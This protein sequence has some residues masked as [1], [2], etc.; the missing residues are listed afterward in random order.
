MP[1]MNSRRLPKSPLTSDVLQWIPDS[2][3]R[4]AAS[5]TVSGTSTLEGATSG[6]DTSVPAMPGKDADQ[7]ASSQGGDNRDDGTVENSSRSSW[8]EL[9]RFVTS[10]EE[11]ESVVRGDVFFVPTR[12][13]R[14]QSWEF[15][16]SLSVEDRPIRNDTS[17][18]FSASALVGQQLFH[19]VQQ[20]LKEELNQSS[21]QDLDQDQ[22]R[23][24]AQ[25]PI[26]GPIQDQDQD[27]DQDQVQVQVQVQVQDQVEDHAIGLSIREGAI[28]SS[29]KHHREAVATGAMEESSAEGSESNT[30]GPVKVG[31]NY[32]RKLP[33]R[34]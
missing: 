31:S 25:G 18:P 6:G 29:R 34:K 9:P 33:F 22:T 3:Q 28:E 14:E 15:S 12:N 23:V 11:T 4:G 20:A 19:S 5:L 1:A 2:I 17:L 32:R 7:L 16:F 26:Q 27:Q 8:P 10:L 21:S 30:R 13:Q 24:Q